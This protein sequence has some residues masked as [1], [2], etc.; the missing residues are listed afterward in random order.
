M[1][2]KLYSSIHNTGTNVEGICR[3]WGIL[4]TVIYPDLKENESQYTQ[5]PVFTPTGFDMAL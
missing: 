4:L 3:G 5:I 1:G 2:Y